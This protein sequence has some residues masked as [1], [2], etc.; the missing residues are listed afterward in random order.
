[1]TKNLKIKIG[2]LFGVIAGIIIGICACTK[3]TALQTGTSV[4]N[5]TEQE[6]QATQTLASAQQCGQTASILRTPVLGQLTTNIVYDSNTSC[7][8]TFTLIFQPAPNHPVSTGSFEVHLSYVNNNASIGTSPYIFSFNVPPLN[9]I[10]ASGVTTCKTDIDL[11]SLNLCSS[12]QYELININLLSTTTSTT[13][14]GPAAISRS[15]VICSGNSTDANQQCNKQL[16]G[17][18]TVFLELCQKLG[19]KTINAQGQCA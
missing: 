16:I 19:F 12:Q 10:I 15:L 17:L 6:Q 18:A 5:L 8:Q 2:I 13:W 14:N 4:N 1:M 3:P 11:A 9:C 7:L